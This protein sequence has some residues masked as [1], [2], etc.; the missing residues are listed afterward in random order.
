MVGRR[1]IRIP[2]AMPIQSSDH[3]GRVQSMLAKKKIEGEKK[4]QKIITSINK[5][6]WKLKAIKNNN[7]T[8]M[9]SPPLEMFHWNRVV[10]D[11]FT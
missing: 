1:L 5:D 7:W 10:V 4:L 2:E 3:L 11:E 9:K 8:K 6:P